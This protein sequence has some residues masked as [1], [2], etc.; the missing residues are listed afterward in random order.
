M[1][2]KIMLSILNFPYV[3]S[4]GVLSINMLVSITILIGLILLVRAIFLKIGDVRMI[5][6]LYL[7]VPLRVIVGIIGGYSTSETTP[8]C[9]ASVNHLLNQSITQIQRGWESGTGTV[10]PVTF[11]LE[12]V[13]LPMQ[14][15]WIWMLG[16]G[17][18]LLLLLIRYFVKR[19][20]DL[21]KKRRMHFDGIRIIMLA[22]FWFNPLMWI[23]AIYSKRDELCYRES[24][25]NK[26]KA[27]EQKRRKIYWVHMWFVT[28]LLIVTVFTSFPYITHL[29]GEQTVKQFYY[30]LD[31]EYTG[32]L[33]RLYPMGE[34]DFKEG[35]RTDKVEKVIRFYDVTNDS[36]YQRYRG[37][38][39]KFVERQVIAVDVIR[40]AYEVSHGMG[41]ER[42]AK[43]ETDVFEIVRRSDGE[44]W[45]IVY[46]NQGNW[47]YWKDF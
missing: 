3:F 45:E 34:G 36:K 22:L 46:W 31:Q 47:G 35:K 10:R 26:E 25:A 39:K 1:I 30:F 41:D 7:L 43:Q 12:A 23:I 11:T 19:K 17:G 18:I 44:D 5:C 40:S 13:S 9:I 28:L 21:E 29:D 24:F 4:K 38:T 15:K 32:G 14:I 27:D 42:Q 8:E 16:G 20:S 37:H 2:E 6:I 33:R